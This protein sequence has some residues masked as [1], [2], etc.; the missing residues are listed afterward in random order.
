MESSQQNNVHFIVFVI[1]LNI[2]QALL[3]RPTQ[4]Y[5]IIVH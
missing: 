1:L 3:E 4:G 5:K 2:V